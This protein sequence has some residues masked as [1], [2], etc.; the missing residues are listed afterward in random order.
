[1][2]IQGFFFF[3]CRLLSII[4]SYKILNI[5]PPCYTISSCYLSILG[6]VVNPILLICLSSPPSRRW[7]FVLVL[8]FG[9]PEAFGVPRPGIRPEPHM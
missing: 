5:I 8:V 4:G 1:M 7:F 9:C 3:F 2:V 6:T